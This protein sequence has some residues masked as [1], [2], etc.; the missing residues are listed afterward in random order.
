[1]VCVS[2]ARIRTPDVGV[3][4]ELARMQ[5]CARRNGSE[6]RFTDA[7][8]ELEALIDLVGLADVL[9]VE[10]RRKTEQRK[11]LRRVEEERDVRDL[12]L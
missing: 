8:E 4:R 6:L 10:V 9:R 7:S 5:L 11:E 3:I 1:M 12:S 2:C